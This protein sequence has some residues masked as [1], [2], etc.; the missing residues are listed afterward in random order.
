MRSPNICLLIGFCSFA[1]LSPGVLSQA[2]QS[3]VVDFT[4]LSVWPNL[5]SCLQ[6]CFNTCGFLGGCPDNVALAVGCETNACLCRPSTLGDGVE[7]VSNLALSRC[8]NLDDQ[9]SATSVLKSYCSVKGY[10]S[11]VAPTLLPPTSGAFTTTATVTVAVATVT[12]S[13]TVV[14]SAS[15]KNISPPWPLGFIFCL[16][17]L[18]LGFPLA[19]SVRNG[20]LTSLGSGR[21][22]L[23]LEHHF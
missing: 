12:V 17:M 14:V 10:T 7:I 4:K 2:L 20:R 11:I 16:G 21:R 3:D 9:T 22:H 19:S 13:H 23:A 18:A 15:S 8:K 6:M 1:I 5:R